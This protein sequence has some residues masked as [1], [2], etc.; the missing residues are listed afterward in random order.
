MRIY[1]HNALEELHVVV[2]LLSLVARNVQSNEVGNLAVE[3]L[4]E[5]LKSHPPEQA[6]LSW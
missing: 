6:L 5:L 2:G 4:V 3:G 1:V